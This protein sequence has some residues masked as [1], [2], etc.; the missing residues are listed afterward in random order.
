[1]KPVKQAF[2]VVIWYLIRGLLKL[3]DK[4]F[5]SEPSRLDSRP[6]KGAI[7]TVDGTDSESVRG[8]FREGALG[9]HLIY[10]F[11]E[12]EICPIETKKIKK[13]NV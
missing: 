6:A 1:M 10:V 7:G 9:V 4:F 5:G 13:L 8:G 11:G 3:N 2:K 12:R